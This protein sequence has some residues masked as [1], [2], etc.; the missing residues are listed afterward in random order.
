MVQTISAL[1]FTTPFLLALLVPLAGITWVVA[2]ARSA[3]LW[4]SL[5]LGCILYFPNASW[6]LIDRSD[7]SDFY[8]RATGT[9]FFSAINVLLFGLVLQALV[10]RAWGRL[11]PLRHNLR[12]AAILFWLILLGNV[13][14][15][16]YLDDV[17]WYQIIGY[18]GLLNVANFML[19]FYVFMACVNSPKD[20]DRLITV[21]LF[22]A[23]TRGLWG[24][25]RFVA[26]GGDPANVYAN[27]QNLDI[28]LTFF[29][30][31]D[32]LIATLAMFVAAWRLVNVKSLSVSAKCMY[33]AII[34][35]ELFIIFFSYR[36]TA[37]GGIALAAVLFAFC[38]TR[39]LRNSLLVVYATVGLPAL[40]Y[41]FTLR[42]GTSGQS[43]SFL[44]RILPDVA[45]GRSFSLTT[46]RFAELYA[47]GLSIKESPWL[48][49]GAWGKYDGSR[50]SELA[51]H[52]GDYGW[53]H[54]GVLHIAL[55]SGAIGVAITVFVFFGL[56]RYVWRHRDS[57]PPAQR[58]IMMAGVAGVLFMLP[59]WLIGTPVIEYRTMQL[60]ALCFAL[61]Y[62][63][64][65]VA[66][67]PK[68]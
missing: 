54:S 46:G 62:M 27:F 10:G 67:Q 66:H 8:N 57:V 13:L 36:R 43:V 23:V 50:F 28:K 26:L 12:L 31:N 32:S 65:A 20:L 38:Q 34:A 5:Y 29:D 24:V 15:G 60:M 45:Q 21:L 3:L 51:W 6:G 49:L 25:F 4:V 17:Y 42:S 11:P 44:E 35:L 22:C 19:G 55:K 58:G 16:S 56:C 64:I 9:F 52:R 14:L 63:A 18:S 53:M 37:W 47:A 39:G 48:G 40:L 41:K 1:F 7:G 33:A 30:I 68:G 61:P 2:G 59:N